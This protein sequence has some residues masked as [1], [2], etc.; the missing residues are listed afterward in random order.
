MITAR[1][2]PPAIRRSRGLTLVEMMVAVAIGV[3][4]VTAMSLLFANNSR[5]RT[6]TERASQKVENGRYALE[7]IAGELEHAGYFALFDPRKLTLP[8]AKPDACATAIADLKAAMPVHVQGYDDGSGGLSCISD[9]KAGTD[10][11]VV[12]RVSTCAAGVGTCPALP[13]GAVG[14]QA[15]SCNDPLQPEL[16]TGVVDNF[17]RFSATAA[18]FDRTRRDCATAAEVQRYFV[19]IYFVANND[20]AGDGVPTLKRTELGAAGGAPE[21]STVSLVQGVE[22]LQL[23]Y[24]MD[25]NTDGNP[26]VYSAAPDSYLNCTAATT[27]TCVGHW[28]SVV[29]SKVYLLAR[30]LD[31]SPGHV[32]DKSYTLG[33]VAD[34]AAGSGAAK[35]VGP[36]SDSF[37]RSVFQEV[38]R[39]QNVS[40][41]RFSP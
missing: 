36:Y 25:T 26:D 38:V 13:A 10:V 4:I 28:S 20:K 2:M 6:E 8:A 17:Y 9:V 19:R 29:T 15:S 24:G 34:A 16:A 32:D 40:G 31:G 21:F 5:S 33:R 12:R 22:N 3:L 30:N 23:E 1:P 39:L 37:K 27:P 7:L 11:L 18:D 14:F 41:R 35:T